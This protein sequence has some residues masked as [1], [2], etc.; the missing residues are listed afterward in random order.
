MRAAAAS[1]AVRGSLM[2]AMAAS[3]WGCW[4]LFLR[5]AEKRGAIPAALEAAAS[6]AA[7][8][9]LSLTLLA[10]AGDRVA[11]RAAPRD[12]AFILVLGVADALNVAFF[13]AAYQRTSVAIAVLTHYT[14]PVLVAVAAPLALGERWRA[15]T[16][17]SVLV[18]IAGL[19]L[20]LAPWSAARRPGDTLGATLGLLSA[21][22]YATNVVVSKRL[23]DVFSGSE[24]AF[25]HGAVSVLILAALVPRGALAH[26]DVVSSLWLA[27]GAL[28]PGAACGLLFVWGLRRVD[29]SRA[30]SLTL[31]EPL[32]ATLTAVALFHEPLGALGAFGGAL[33][34][35]GAAIAI[36]A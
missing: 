35:G 24:M 17:A 20:L 23:T 8:T 6:L 31:L 29:A 32:V 25:Y 36:A 1:R 22:C 13:F 5:Q 21:V 34:L 18:S 10:G 3:G 7:L 4:P 15:R 27:G 2:V 30:S 28:V 12:W 14:T 26:V 11:R 9:L 33:V 16:F 19:V